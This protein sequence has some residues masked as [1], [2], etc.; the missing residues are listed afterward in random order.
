MFR[1]YVL[2]ALIS[3]LIIDLLIFS[4]LLV[5]KIAKNDVK[6]RKVKIQNK[7]DKLFLH[8]IMDTDQSM[9]ITPKTHLEKQVL[10]E[11]VLH[12]NTVL[13]GDVRKKLLDNI[14]KSFISV[15]INRYLRSKSIWKNKVGTF[16]IG[17]YELNDLLP[18]LLEQ[19]NT[20]DQELLFVTARSIIVVSND[21]YIEDILQV[22][23]RREK[24]TKQN[25]LTLIDLV[26]GDI[27]AIL[28]KAMVE[29]NSFLR[30][31][32]LEEL[33]KRNYMKSIYWIKCMLT[34]SE[35]ELRIAALKASYSLGDIG[36]ESY[37]QGLYQ[38]QTDP[39]WEVRAFLAKFLMKVNRSPAIDILTNLMSDQNWYVRYNA[40]NALLAQGE[41]GELALMELL[42]SE[43]AFAR[44]AAHA[45]LQRG[46][47]L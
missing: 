26:E 20:P 39:E 19:L 44:D 28:D 14:D 2:V 16:L 35:K 17:E 41:K 6:R 33:G 15:R 12:Y 40:S 22:V 46:I 3:M 27:E 10:H 31:I 32:A 45:V 21:Q 30:A 47:L 8:L 24:M 29:G 18:T 36:D 34:Q 43:D 23:T 11:L 7:Y 37:L 13:S 42:K 1:Q 25:V 4:F 5:K 9:T 38:L